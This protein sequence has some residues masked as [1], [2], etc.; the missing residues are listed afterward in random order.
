MN[1]AS[2]HKQT[3]VIGATFLIALILTIIPLPGVII[4]FRPAWV[5][6]TLLFWLL[7]IPH[8][9]GILLGWSM[10]FLVDLLTGG[11][12][13]VNALL[14]TLVTFFLLKFHLVVRGLSAVQKFFFVA[15]LQTI[16]LLVQ[17]LVLRGHS[18]FASNWLYW[19]PVISTACCWVLV[20]TLLRDVQ[21]R[22][23]I[24]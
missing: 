11:A 12:L 15:V 17:Y 13:G 4:W 5:M 20:R 21:L 6:L 7:V 1:K 2:R 10:G 22:Y 16:I 23:R 18:G 3:L 9:V 24:G 19:M 14:F 8:R